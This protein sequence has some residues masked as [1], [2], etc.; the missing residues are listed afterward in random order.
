ME[1]NTYKKP[2]LHKLIYEFSY[3]YVEY[4]LGVDVDGKF[5][6]N[7]LELVRDENGEG[8]DWETVFSTKSDSFIELKELFY[9]FHTLV[10][11]PEVKLEGGFEDGTYKFPFKQSK[12]D[13]LFEL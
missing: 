2:E 10:V 1:N 11:P 7:I 5:G 8:L 6:L 4:H 9:T 13:A 12:F 3:D